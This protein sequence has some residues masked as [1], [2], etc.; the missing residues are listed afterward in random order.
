M[1]VCTAHVFIAFMYK[2]KEQCSPKPVSSTAPR[3]LQETLPRWWKSGFTVVFS[4]IPQSILTFWVVILRSMALVSLMIF[5]DSSVGIKRKVK[6]GL[7][8]GRSKSWSKGKN[9]EL[10][11]IRRRGD[12]VEGRREFSF[13]FLPAIFS[14]FSLTLIIFPLFSL[15][16]LLTY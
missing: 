4:Y 2:Y 8:Y 14:L 7:K 15:S 3:N 16:V 10:I 12:S 6:T 1:K 11:G 9:K 5:R 13:F